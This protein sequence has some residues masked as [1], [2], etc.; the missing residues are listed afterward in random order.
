MSHDTGKVEVCGIDEKFIYTRYQQ[1][2]DAENEF[3][4]Q[5]YHR[6]DKASWL[7]QLKPVS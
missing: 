2:K 5:V 1:A 6:D 4:F 3:K 7:D